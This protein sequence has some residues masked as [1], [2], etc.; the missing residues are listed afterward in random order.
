MKRYHGVAVWAGLISGVCVWGLLCSSRAPSGEL[1]PPGPPAKSMHT[2][3]EIYANTA[4]VVVPPEALAT[5]GGPVYLQVHGVEG[6]VTEGDRKGWIEIFGFVNDMEFAADHLGGGGAGK[7]QFAPVVVTKQLDKAS[8]KLAL[9]CCKGT[10]SS[11]V[12]IEWPRD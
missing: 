9:A 2:L 6:G 10:I 4:R 5:A 11:R 12:R 1:Q 3:D 8:P 7:V